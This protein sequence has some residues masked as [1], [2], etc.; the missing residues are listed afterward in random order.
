[1]AGAGIR[2]FAPQPVDWQRIEE[3][4]GRSLVPADRDA[5]VVLVKNYFRWQPSEAR[6]P[7]AEDA[8]RYLN[9]LE[10]AGKQ[11]WDVLLEKERTPITGARDHAHIAERDM[12]RGV[13]ISYVQSR[14]R[15]T[16][17]GVRF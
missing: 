6:A 7:F 4:Y 1:M 8:T 3:A 12:M 13:A 17:G 16:P 11:F 2:N 9:R 15:Q 10:K 14:V 5:L